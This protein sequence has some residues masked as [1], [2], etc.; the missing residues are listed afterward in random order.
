M[1]IGQC[2]LLILAM[3]ILS[4]LDN[5]WSNSPAEP[6]RFATVSALSVRSRAGHA[7][8]NVHYIAIQLDQYLRGQGPRVLFSEISRGSAVG[9]DWKEGVR[10]ATVAAANTLGQDYRNWVVIIK[11]PHQQQPHGRIQI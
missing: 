2:G 10:V 11:N 7:I 8:G 3:L 1:T 9:D 4:V 6:H 5:T